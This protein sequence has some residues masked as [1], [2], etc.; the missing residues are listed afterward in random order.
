M[1]ELI[2]AVGETIGW[3]FIGVLVLYAA[4]RLFDW[5]DPINHQA[6]LRQGNVAVAIFV[7][8]VIL[9]LAAIVVAVIVT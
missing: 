9:A 7:G 6:E 4:T 3:A 1:M 8:S 5:I 2:Q